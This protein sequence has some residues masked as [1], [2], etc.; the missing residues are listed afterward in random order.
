[1]TREFINSGMATIGKKL[2]LMKGRTEDRNDFFS[3]IIA[4]IV[5]F[6]FIITF[7]LSSNIVNHCCKVS[8]DFKVILNIN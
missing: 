5:S 2:R 8:L 1:M 6:R 4:F 7:G 3:K